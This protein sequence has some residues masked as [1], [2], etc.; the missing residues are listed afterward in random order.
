METD[1]WRFLPAPTSADHDWA[2]DN[3]GKWRYFVDPEV[4]PETS[5]WPEDCMSGWGSDDLG[6]LTQVWLNPDFEPS[7]ETA[8]MDLTTEFELVLWR[9]TRGFADY[10]AFIG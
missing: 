4:D 8:Q 3:P 9:T 2:R 1:P 7:P 5:R 6:N 10:D